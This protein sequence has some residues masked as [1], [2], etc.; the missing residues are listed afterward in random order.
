M[1]SEVV[2]TYALCGFANLSAIGVQLGGLIPMAPERR[3]DLASVSVRALISGSIAC[4][5]TACIAGKFC[6]RLVV[7]S[8]FDVDFWFS[9]SL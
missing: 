1:R 5:M 2:A 3:G 6:K 9:V 4:F 7:F 8:N